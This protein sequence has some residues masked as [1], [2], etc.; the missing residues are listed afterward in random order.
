MDNSALF[1]QKASLYAAFR[2]L[3]NADG[4]KYL[5]D[6]KIVDKNDLITDIG[7]GT[8]ILTRPFLEYGNKVI[9]I[10]PNQEMRTIAF[11]KLRGYE[12][13]H[14][15]SAT[16]ECTTLADYSIDVVIVGQ[17]FHWFDTAAFKRECQR[18]LKGK[19][20]VILMWNRKQQNC[21]LEI[22][23]RKIRSKY[24]LANDKYNNNW[25]LREQAVK[26]FYNQNFCYKEFDNPIRNTYQEF[27][28][29]S[30]SDSRAPLPKS[31]EYIQYREELDSY[32]H[33]Y[34]VEGRLIIPNQTII[35]W[36]Y[37]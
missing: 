32:F 36:G 7:A 6:H 18:I 3:Y 4:I 35:Y 34:S 25:H 13:F 1:N 28:G 31:A 24:C 22:E 15:I 27:I 37:L 20:L 11:A 26:Q 9:A 17:A 29:R 2:P 8:G 23:R 16:A 33:K 10:E 19:K 30:L 21:E 12:N 5:Y 14:T